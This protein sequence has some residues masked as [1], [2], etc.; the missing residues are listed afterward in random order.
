[1]E[2]ALNKYYILK[3]NNINV[4]HFVINKY[5]YLKYLKMKYFNKNI[6]YILK[7]KNSF[8][9]SKNLFKMHFIHLNIL[10]KFIIFCVHL[11][12]LLLFI[13]IF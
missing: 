13:S 2:S 7:K 9:K 8:L 1:M 3:I 5:F 6:Y 11:F 12:K 4:I 10:N